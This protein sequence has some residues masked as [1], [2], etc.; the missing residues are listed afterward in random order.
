MNIWVIP[1]PYIFHVTY[2]HL[3]KT[4]TQEAKQLVLQ[5]TCRREGNSVC[6][7]MYTHEEHP[8]HSFGPY[9]TRVWNTV[10]YKPCHFFMY[11]KVNH[12][13]RSLFP[14]DRE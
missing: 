7:K 1:V 9:K 13:L 11:G 6:T 4:I 3:N 5:P 14:L 12:G 10:K 8:A 2:R